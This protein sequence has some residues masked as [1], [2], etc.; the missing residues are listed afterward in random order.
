MGKNVVSR[1]FLGGGALL[2]WGLFTP[3]HSNQ[4]HPIP[5]P[6]AADQDPMDGGQ[7]LEGFESDSPFSEDTMDERA[8]FQNPQ[9]VCQFVHFERSTEKGLRFFYTGGQGVCELKHFDA[10]NPHPFG[11]HCWQRGE[12]KAASLTCKDKDATQCVSAPE[13][14]LRV[15]V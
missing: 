1:L 11:F 15:A 10:K 13:M 14:G 7:I 5:S 8:A 12:K 9:D 4:F 3:S 2:V 6:Y